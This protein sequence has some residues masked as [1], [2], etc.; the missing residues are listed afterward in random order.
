[1]LSIKHKTFITDINLP[2]ELSFYFLNPII[3][4][5]ASRKD[6]RLL[7][8]SFVI[9]DFNEKQLIY[10]K[11]FLPENVDIVEQDPDQRIMRI[12]NPRYN[13]HRSLEIKKD[14][15]F[16]TFV[17]TGKYFYRV[18]RKTGLT[19][20]FTTN[21]LSKIIG[22]NIENI[23]CTPCKENGFLYTTA[24]S[25]DRDVPKNLFFIKVDMNLEKYEVIHKEENF[26]GSSPHVTKKF[27][28]YIFCSEFSRE[29]LNFNGQTGRSLDLM[30][31]VFR[32]LYEEFCT[33]KGLVFSEGNFLKNNSVS[34]ENV[35]LEE[36]FTSFVK[37][38]GKNLLEICQRN[39]KYNFTAEQGLISILDIKNKK[40]NYYKTSTC[41]PAHFEID[42][43]SNNVYVSS[44]NFV[45]L[46]KHYYL[47]PS[48][49]DKFSFKDGELKKELSFSENSGY[50]F[51]THKVFKYEG[52][53]YICTFGY[54]TRL[55]FI[56]ADTMQMVFYEDIEY[57]NVL[58][59]ED[60]IVDFINSNPQMNNITIKAI[61]VSSDG[62]YLI[63][64]S[65]N[66]IYFYDFKER[67][68]FY[69]LRYLADVSLDKYLNLKDFYHKTTHFDFLN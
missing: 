67:K 59:K 21:D 17:E 53:T 62:R 42:E 57:Q 44:H 27:G 38:K 18:N 36:N 66:F 19:Q 13:P 69:K 10:I 15:S 6:S 64:L 7:F 37:E 25:T 40:L 34:V 1:M 68:I 41:T 55:F 31:F 43:E 5:L 26:L 33:K 61:E 8:I 11:T 49:I 63:L 54:P 45:F 60:D 52:K 12:F 32:D 50:R 30:N 46:D 48:A 39:K 58:P 23:S 3:F 56:D 35:K 16:L 29:R 14:E 2:K 47:G 28:E 51:T 4:Y 20:I 9:L 22:E 24:V 65:Y